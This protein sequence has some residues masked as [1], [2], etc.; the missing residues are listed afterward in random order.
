MSAEDVNARDVGNAQT[1]VFWMKNQDDFA[2]NTN[3]LE[4]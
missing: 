2:L 3:F 4:C 1:L